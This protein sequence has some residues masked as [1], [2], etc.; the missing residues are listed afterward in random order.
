MP[1]SRAKGL[2]GEREVRE[3]YERYGFTVKRRYKSDAQTE[4][5]P[6]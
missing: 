2:Q 1:D 5:V 4:E 6:Y 3:L